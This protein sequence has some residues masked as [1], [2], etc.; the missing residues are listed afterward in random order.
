MPDSLR[1]GRR[2]DPDTRRAWQQRLQRFPHSGLTVTAFCAR[3]RVS[4]ASFYAWKRRLA[5]HPA[6]EPAPRFVPVRV[7][8]PPLS[9][10]VE[11][12]LP[13][14]LILRLAPGVDLA[15]LR[16]LLGLL[17]DTAC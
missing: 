16:Q 10:P 4:V 3:E 5:A 1:P 15:W 2:P 9:V 13:S 7:V 12:L 11:V 8:T 14:G 17:G 6:P